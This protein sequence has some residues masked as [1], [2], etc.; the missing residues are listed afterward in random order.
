MALN[1]SPEFKSSST[2]PSAA[3]RLGTW[4]H[5]LSSLRRALLWNPLYQISSMWAKT[6]WNRRF[7]HIAYVFLCFKPRSPWCEAILDPGTLVLNKLAKFF[8][9]CKNSHAHLQYIQ[10]KYAWFQ[11][12]PLKTVRGVD[13]TNSIPYNAKMTKF[14]RLLFCQN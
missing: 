11:N 2:K 1:R 8:F 10:N 4:G 5:H 14:E 13:Y 9:V 12:G 6:F 7:F 3:Q